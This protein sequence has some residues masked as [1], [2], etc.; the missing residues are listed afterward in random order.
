[1]LYEKK[2]KYLD[3]CEDGERIKGGGVV[4]LEQRKDCVAVEIMVQGV[5]YTKPQV[6]DVFLR[7]GGQTHPLGKMEICDGKGTFHYQFREPIPVEKWEELHILLSDTG[8]IVARWQRKSETTAFHSGLAEDVHRSI[9]NEEFTVHQNDG[10]G[11]AEKEKMGLVGEFYEEDWTADETETRKADMPEMFPEKPKMPEQKKI[12]E[13]SRIAEEKWQQLWTVYPH[14]RPYGDEREYL[15]IRPADFVIFNEESYKKL[16]NSFLLHGYYNYGH[17][18]LAR[19]R[20]QSEYVY[21]VGTPGSYFERE[22]QVAIMFGFESFE[23][24]KEPAQAGDFGYY[25]MRGAL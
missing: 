12:D 23:C 10:T 14:I 20:R 13:K 21:Y 2:I 19:V 22:K 25:M 16:N 5:P 6:G 9:G 24:E 11:P 17:L 4:K 1:M 3:Y 15:S 18:I 8:E 7:A